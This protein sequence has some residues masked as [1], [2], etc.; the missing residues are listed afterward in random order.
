M[1]DQFSTVFG[2]ILDLK[3]LFWKFITNILKILTSR[4]F[5][6]I[7]GDLKWKKTENYVEINHVNKYTKFDFH[8]FPRIS[9]NQIFTTD[10]R[11]ESYDQGLRKKIWKIYITGFQEKIIF[12]TCHI[13]GQILDLT[14][15]SI[16]DEISR[17]D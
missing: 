10:F 3:L 12:K 11:T 9:A 7:F 6:E 13:L 17:F 15:I 5:A 16:F 8:Y 1:F 14:K 4:N 2:R